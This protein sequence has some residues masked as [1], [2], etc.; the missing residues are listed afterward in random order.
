MSSTSVSMFFSISPQKCALTERTG[1]PVDFSTPPVSQQT[2]C[3]YVNLFREVVVY[4][5]FHSLWQATLLVSVRI[6]L[7]QRGKLYPIIGLVFQNPDSLRVHTRTL[8][9]AVVTE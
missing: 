9:L 6:I 1:H 8:T 7:V 3:C 2:F 4:V 5:R